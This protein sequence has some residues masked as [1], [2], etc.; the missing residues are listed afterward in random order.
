MKYGI[1]VRLDGLTQ[2]SGRLAGSAL[3]TVLRW[4]TLTCYDEC[5][6][7][8]RQVWAISYA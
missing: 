2:Y 8:T 7:R 3:P 1:E 4:H 5:Q 6:Q